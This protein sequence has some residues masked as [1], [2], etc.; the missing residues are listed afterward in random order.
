ML[1]VLSSVNKNLKIQCH[2]TNMTVY[3]IETFNTIK[4]VA[5]ADCIHRLDKTLG[6]YIRDITEREYENCKIYSIVFKGL[7]KINEILD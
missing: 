7:D 2:L 5:Y 4:C 3:D 6:K 1:K